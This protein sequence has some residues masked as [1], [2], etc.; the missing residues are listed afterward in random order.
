MDADG[1]MAIEIAKQTGAT[2][3]GITLSENQFATASKAQEGLSEKLL[4]SY[5][6][7]EIVN[8]I[9]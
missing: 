8:M 7:I 3:K 1:I 2:V 9:E 4:L 5:K 6:I